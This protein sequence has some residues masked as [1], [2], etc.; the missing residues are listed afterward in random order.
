MIDNYA[1]A[2][3]L[4]ENMKAHLPILARPTKELIQAMEDTEL[5]L[6]KGQELQINSVLYMGDEG[7]IGCSISMPKD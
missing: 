6:A 5:K 3:E 4:V 2:M 7:G 1:E